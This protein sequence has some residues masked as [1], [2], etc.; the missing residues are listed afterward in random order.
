MRMRVAIR[1]VMCAALL[2]LG[3]CGVYSK[4]DEGRVQA[5]QQP[6]GGNVSVNTPKSTDE[7]LADCR[8]R[9]VK[10]IRRRAELQKEM[11]TLETFAKDAMTT[12][13]VFCYKQQLIELEAE[14]Q[15]IQ[16]EMHN[17]LQLTR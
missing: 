4:A 9:L 5:Q 16:A 6:K 15:A 12:E 14:I 1:E 11:L 8:S 3:V 2:A 10:A 13:L 17:L 7:M